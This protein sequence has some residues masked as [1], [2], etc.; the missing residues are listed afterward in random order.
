MTASGRLALLLAAIAAAVCGYLFLEPNPPG[1]SDVS[2]PIAKISRGAAG[3][4]FDPEIRV[5][6]TADRPP[7]LSIRCDRAYRIVP[8]GSDRVLARGRSLARC[9]VSA[10]GNGLKLGSNRLPA[11]RVELI[12]EQSPGVWVD[13]RQYRGR[14]RIFRLRNGDLFAINVLPLEQ[15][16]ACVLDSE[17]PIAF[18]R[19]ARRAQAIAARTYALYQMEHNRGHPYFD[20]YDTARSQKYLGVKYPNGNGKLWA[21]E[22]DDSREVVAST[23]G[24]VCVYEGRLFCTY[25]SACCGGRTTLGTDL[26]SDAAPILKSVRCEWCRD[27]DLYR[28]TRTVPLADLTRGTNLGRVTSVRDQ[29]ADVLASRPTDVVTLSDGRRTSRVSHWDLRRHDL[30]SPLFR[31]ESSG[32]NLNVSGRGHGHGVGFC[33]WGARGQSAAGRPA[34]E[35]LQFYYPGC[36]IVRLVQR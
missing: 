9:D 30:P 19:E 34:E 2:L 28:W 21:G 20:L 33:Q 11:T 31:A 22:S 23:R 4:A 7:N 16:V 14:I 26:F 10:T 3:P 13:G 8:V 27:A 1:G 36:R 6:L 32:R 18:G 5:N 12:P 25:F 15:Y 35:I 24:L 29:S 17:M